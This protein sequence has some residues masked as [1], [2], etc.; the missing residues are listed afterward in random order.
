MQDDTI[1][2]FGNQKEVRRI[3]QDFFYIGY[4]CFSAKPAFKFIETRVS[5]NSKF[6]LTLS[7]VDS[8]LSQ[9]DFTLFIRSAQWF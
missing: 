8:K 2:K 6:F 1:Y 9:M 3:V 5:I 4:S 7:D